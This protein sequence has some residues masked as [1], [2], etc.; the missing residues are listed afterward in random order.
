MKPVLTVRHLNVE[1][2]SRTLI[3]DLSFRVK[4]GTLTWITGENG[5]GKTTL[6]RVLLKA[7][8]HSNSAV[9]LL[10]SRRRVQCVPQFRNVAADYPLTIRD[11]VGLSANQSWLPWLNRPEKL[12]LNQ[13]MKQTHLTKLANESLGE[14]SGGEQQRAFLAQALLTKPKLLILDEATA[15]LDTEAK[16]D[17]LRVV[18]QAVKKFQIAVL[19]ITH[20]PTLV[21]RFG[22]YELRIKDHRGQVKSLGG[23]D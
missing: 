19:F 22:N 15:S 11:F 2:G 14:A 12:L 8:W 3:R 20:D 7:F 18:E 4:P 16:V 13:V 1:I 17:F 5:V 23:Q 10:I 21:H 6:V 9:Q